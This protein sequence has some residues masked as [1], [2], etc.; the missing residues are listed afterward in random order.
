MA[1]IP[2]ATAILSDAADKKALLLFTSGYERVA[3]VY[4]RPTAAS[5]QLDNWNA[6]S[7]NARPHSS[8]TATLERKSPEP[9][10]SATFGTTTA[11]PGA[12]VTSA[13]F[14]EYRSMMAAHVPPPHA[15]NQRYAQPLT[16]AQEV[17]WRVH[18][19]WANTGVIRTVHADRH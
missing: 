5:F 10:M 7:R 4:S 8:A 16:A 1:S 12:A 18:E 14:G 9:A 17:G 19:N 11:I 6:A 2:S 15:P 13:S 3:G